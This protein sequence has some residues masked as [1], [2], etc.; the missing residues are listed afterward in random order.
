MKD[1]NNQN[2]RRNSRADSQKLTVVGI[3]YNVGPDA[4]DRLRRIFTI[5]LRH[6]ARDRQATTKKDAHIDAVNCKNHAGEEA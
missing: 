5:L 4:E 3:D 1:A 2:K 6:A